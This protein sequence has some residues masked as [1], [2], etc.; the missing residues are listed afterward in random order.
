MAATSRLALASGIVSVIG[1]VVYGCSST[2]GGGVAEDDR[3]EAGAHPATPTGGE[4]GTG[5]TTSDAGAD[6]SSPPPAQT[7]AIFASTTGNAPALA[8]AACKTCM[9]QRCCA[10]TTACFG[11][12]PSDAGLDGS[13]GKKTS[14]ELFGECELGCNG[15]VACEDQCSV[16]YGEP[17]ADDYA[18]YDG[19]LSGPAPTGCADFC[20]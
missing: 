10:Q 11:G 7:C 15:N 6:T 8:P 2:D 12:K 19:C 14:C 3:T 9:A 13:N 1:S 20:N 16:V 5:A 4:A 18:A 17:A